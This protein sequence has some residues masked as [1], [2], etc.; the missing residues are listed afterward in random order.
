MT[1]GIEPIDFS[2]N[3]LNYNIVRLEIIGD[4]SI[5]LVDCGFY[6][7]STS[8]TITTMIP[9][10]DTESSIV[11]L[12]QL[13]WFDASAPFGGLYREIDVE[14]NAGN[15]YTTAFRGDLYV[16]DSWQEYILDR[17]YS[18]FSGS[19]I[20]IKL[21]Q[22]FAFYSGFVYIYGDDEL[23]FASDEVTMG[24]LPQDFLINVSNIYKLRIEIVG[25]G[26]AYIGN[27]YLLKK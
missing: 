5:R 22:H 6:K 20:L 24:F 18:T 15:S 7:D 2:V 19:V 14:D 17:K 27:P 3:I 11:S 21:F 4:Q 25:D 26:A 13:D 12:E 23:L 10:Q 16:K 1:K 8:P 9:P